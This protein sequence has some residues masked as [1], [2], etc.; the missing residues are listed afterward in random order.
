M[1][2]YEQTD[3][4]NY[5]SNSFHSQPQTTEI[6][7]LSHAISDDPQQFLDVVGIPKWDATMTQEY[8]S[9]MKTHT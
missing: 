3:F 2:G 6:L 9:L 8:S 1:Y 7:L 5:A 4:S